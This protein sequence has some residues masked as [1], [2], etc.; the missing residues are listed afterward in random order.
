MTHRISAAVLQTSLAIAALLSAGQAFAQAPPGAAQ[1]GQIERQFLPPPTPVPPGAT[2]PVPAAPDFRAPANAESIRFVLRRVEIDGATAYG[3]DTLANAWQDRVG[4][5]VSLADVYG[6]AQRLTVMYRNDGF[7]LSRVIVP[8]Q[9]IADGVV[10]LRAV[11]GYIDGV[12]LQGDVGALE[13]A[14]VARAAPL[15]M[16]RPLSAAVLER[17][18][19]L[20][21]DLPGVRAQ[22][23]L[24]PSA[25][26]V[27]AADVVIEVNQSTLYG[28]VEVNN[29]G[30]RSL[31]P[32]RIEAQGSVNNLAGVPS[33]LS[34]SG[35]STPDDELRYGALSAD[36]PLGDSGLVAS[37]TVSYAQAHPDPK[38]SFNV[39]YKTE[40]TSGNLQLAYPLLRSLNRNLELRAALNS[41][42]GS[43]DANGA[44]LSTDRIRSVRLGVRFDLV[45]S[46]SGVD[47]VDVELSRGLDALGARESGATDLSNP[48][49]RSDYS[50]AVLYMARVQGLSQRWSALLA[51]QAQR[52]FDDLLTPERFSYGGS[53]FGRGYDPSELLGDDG[54]AVKLEMR[55]DAPALVEGFRPL[56]YGFYEIGK[57]WRRHAA[58]LDSMDSAATAGL[59]ARFDFSQRW[60]GYLEVA[61]PLTRDVAGEGDRDARV[62]VG[63]RVALY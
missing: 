27:A 16:A 36:L 30:S 23:V 55:Y 48:Y 52:A 39:E 37:A 29:R 34:L 62:Y 21:N 26:A 20:I 10:K 8:E 60:S 1:P 15:R 4:Q 5:T 17:Q 61:K 45:D 2:V 43:T 63:L 40:S 25:G 13:G 3:S 57:V 59:G 14:I 11:E 46:L 24:K 19:L 54:A 33:R 32:W 51:L 53:G 22:A 18:L 12:Q 56:L 49:G 58:G 47:L 9:D 38:R 42:D 44:R 50:K 41:I 28:S 7:I 35:S 31:G 6:W